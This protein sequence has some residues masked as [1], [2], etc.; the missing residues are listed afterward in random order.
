MT[1][2]A[3]YGR[4]EVGSSKAEFKPKIYKTNE[5]EDRNGTEEKSDSVNGEF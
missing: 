3:V 5:T 2:Q 1:M 4:K